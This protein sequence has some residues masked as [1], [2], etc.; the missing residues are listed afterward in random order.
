M[1]VKVDVCDEDTEEQNV[2]VC[3]EVEGGHISGG[4]WRVPKIHPG[5]VDL[6]RRS[7]FQR[8]CVRVYISVD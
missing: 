2:D 7:C 6:T 4:K 1:F 3:G 8:L 5:D